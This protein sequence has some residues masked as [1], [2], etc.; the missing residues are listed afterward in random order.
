MGPAE[1][2]DAV[3]VVDNVDDA[4]STPSP[5]M[6]LL[7][8]PIPMELVALLS[9]ASATTAGGGGSSDVDGSDGALRGSSPTAALLSFS[10]EFCSAPL[11]INRMTTTHEAIARIKTSNNTA[12]L[13]LR[14]FVFFFPNTTLQHPASLVQHPVPS[15]SSYFFSPS[16]ISCMDAY[17]GFPVLSTSPPPFPVRI[18]LLGLYVGMFISS[19]SSGG[20]DCCTTSKAGSS[21]PCRRT[22]LP[23]P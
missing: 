3:G 5:S 10:F 7:S 4:S 1:G 21:P 6:V 14:L 16:N 9:S 15:S 13:T 19:S 12:T 23:P 22:P 20:G 17:L 18:L 8:V 2:G 11:P